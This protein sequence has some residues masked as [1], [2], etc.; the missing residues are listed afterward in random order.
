MEDIEDALVQIGLTKNE[1]MVFFMC[2]Q[3]GMVTAG[4]IAKKCRLHRTSV[5]DIVGRLVAKGLL[6]HIIKE[7][8]MYFEAT[9]PQNLY[10]IINEKEYVLKAIMPKLMLAKKMSRGK[11]EAYVYEGVHAFLRLRFG[12]LRYKEEILV[13]G[14]PKTASETVAAKLN[15][16]HKERIKM[17]IPMKHIYNYNAHE[18]ISYL[19]ALPLTEARF[20]PQKYESQVSTCICGDEVS[21]TLWTSPP[22]IIQVVNKQIAESYRRFFYLLWSNAKK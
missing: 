15:N 20:L 22:L 18:R 11:G 21:L 12:L 7:K 16:F 10:Q 19:N 13:Y 1:A 8:V 2:L 9:E 3:E 4:T 14:V 5:Y 6:S 17:K